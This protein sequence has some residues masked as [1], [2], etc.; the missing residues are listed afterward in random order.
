MS[1]SDER[2]I[3]LA[4][5]LAWHLFE[6]Q[7]DTSELKKCLDYYRASEDRARFLQMLDIRS[8]KSGLFQRSNKTRDYYREMNRKI[9]DVLGLPEMEP[10][11]DLQ[12]LG[13][14]FRLMQ[15]YDEEKPSHAITRSSFKAKQESPSTLSHPDIPQKR[16]TGIV[17]WF[18]DQTKGYGFIEPDDDGEDVFVHISQTPERQGLRENQRVSFVM[19]KG[20]QG[21]DQAQNVQP[22]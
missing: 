16:R 2:A 6:S 21:R 17:K 18:D 3:E 22:E 4:D 5:E 14:A 7:C 10:S 8:G 11:D 19:G 9:L 12:V 1:I 13:W 15:Y 20:P